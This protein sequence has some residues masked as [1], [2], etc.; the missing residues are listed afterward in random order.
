ME[1]GPHGCFGSGLT[2][3]GSVLRGSLL[4]TSD[5][6]LFSHLLFISFSPM[7]SPSDVQPFTCLVS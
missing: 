5:F 2:V 3:P 1:K 4:H 7:L 6:P